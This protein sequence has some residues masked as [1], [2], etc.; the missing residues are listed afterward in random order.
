MC[1]SDLEIEVREGVWCTEH[2]KPRWGL[3]VE[4]CHIGALQ[5]R[6]LDC[7]GEQSGQPVA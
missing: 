6:S 4:P 2:M 5:D 1:S 7:A 3:P